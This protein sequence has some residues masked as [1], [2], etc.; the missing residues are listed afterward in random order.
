MRENNGT[1]DV[2]QAA[3]P[4]LKQSIGVFH[5]GPIEINALEALQVKTFDIWEKDVR[6]G[7]IYGYQLCFCF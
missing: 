2:F 4:Y 1:G 3:Y 7:A 5:A 6:Y